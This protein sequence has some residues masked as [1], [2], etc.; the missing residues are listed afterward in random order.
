[1]TVELEHVEVEN[2]EAW[3]TA[4]NED[5]IVDEIIAKSNLDQDI[6]VST[7]KLNLLVDNE[8]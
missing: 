3:N 2:I 8:E 4:K 7:N 5:F 1:L 6:A